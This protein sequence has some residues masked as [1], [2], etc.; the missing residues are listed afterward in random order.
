VKILRSDKAKEYFSS[1][2]IH[3]MIEQGIIHQSSCAL[4]Y[5]LK[6]SQR[7]LFRRFAY[8]VRAF[9]LS[10]SYKDDFV[11]WQQ[12]QGKNLLLV[13][14]VDDIIINDD[15]QGIVDLKC[16]LQ[17]KNLGFLQYFLGIEITKV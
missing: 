12:H 9:G 7:A 6:Q 13:V 8:V 4:L 11:F 15:A 1:F 10:R 3:F 16:F 17:T 14:F 5:E 2:F